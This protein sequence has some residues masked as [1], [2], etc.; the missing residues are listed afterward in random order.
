MC[1]KHDFNLTKRPILTRPGSLELDF[2]YV[3]GLCV[4]K[5]MDVAD[6][7]GVEE[8]GRVNGT[9]GRPTAATDGKRSGLCP[10]G[11]HRSRSAAG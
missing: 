1:R 10:S 9:A 6:V 4:R 7:F 3:Y 2:G 11:P 5:E 8:T